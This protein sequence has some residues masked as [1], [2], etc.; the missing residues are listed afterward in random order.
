MLNNHRVNTNKEIRQVQKTFNDGVCTIFEANERTLIRKKGKFFF[1]NESVGVGHYYEAYNNNISVD[2]QIGVLIND[3]IDTMDIVKI[4]CD[5]YRIVRMQ[6]KNNRKPNY[7][8][9]SLSKCN[10]SLKEITCD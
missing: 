1:S 8:V 9:I 6:Y 10:F 4:G 2:R 7:W 3:I 5:Y